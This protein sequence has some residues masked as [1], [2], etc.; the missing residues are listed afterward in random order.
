MADNNEIIKC[1][2]EIYDLR[3]YKRDWCLGRATVAK[4]KSKAFREG[5]DIKIKG[6]IPQIQIGNLYNVMLE[7]DDD[8]KYGLQYMVKSLFSAITFRAD[9]VVGQKRFL[10]SIFTTLQVE[11][12]YN[13][14]EDPYSVLEEGDAA[15]LVQVKGVGMKKAESYI[16]RFK[17]NLNKARIYVELEDFNLTNNMIDKLLDRYT[18]PE[19]V[20]QKVKDNPY[21]LCNEVGGIG[22]KTADRIAMDGGIGPHSPKR[23]TAFIAHY[24]NL[25]GENGSSWITPDELMGAILEELGE[26]IPDEPISESLKSLIDDGTVWHSENKDKIGLRRYYEIERKIAQELIRIRDAESNIRVP[27]NWRDILKYIEQNQGWSFTDEQLNGIETG[28]KN[29]I[30]V[31]TGPGG[32]VD[33]DTEYF[34]G[35]EWKKISEYTDEEKVLQYSGDGSAQLVYPINYIKKK[36]SHLWHF[37]TKYGLDQCLS[38]DHQVCYI[39]SK[40]NIYSKS[41]SE[42]MQN[43]QNTSTGFSGKFI[44]TFSYEGH[45]IDLTDDEIRLMVAT[46]ADGSFDYRSVCLSDDT[47]RKA[48]FHLKKKRKKDRLVQLFN[49]C[50]ISYTEKESAEKG[51][52]DYYAIVPFRAKHFPKEWYNCSKHQFEIIADEALYWDSYFNEKNNFVS[53]NKDDADFI[54][55]VN[56][57]LGKRTTIQIDDRVGQE[58][59]TANKK[60]IRQSIAYNV[61]TTN[62]TLICLDKDKRRPGGETKFEKYIPLDGY[63][64]CFSVPSN[65]LVLR[66]NNKI[67]ITGNCGKTSIVSGILEVLKGYSRVSCA[68]SGRA[69]SRMQEVTGEEGKTIHSLLGY[70]KGNKNGFVYHD[71]N[72]L[73]ADIYIVDEISMLDA[74]LFYNLLRAIPSGSKLFLLG[75]TAQLEAIGTG[76]IAHDIIESDEISVSKL[77]KIHRQAA[78]SAIITESIKLRNG[79]QLIEKNW[80]GQE[81]RGELQ[82]LYLSCFSDINNTFYKITEIFSTLMSYPEFDILQ[83]QIIVPVKSRGNACTYELNNAI[84]DLYNPLID[85]QREEIIFNSGKTYVFREGDKVINRVNNYKV[86]PSIYNGNIGIIQGWDYNE[87]G[88]EIMIIDFIGIGRVEL[89]KKFWNNLE[90]AYAITTHLSQGSEFDYVIYGLDFS[91]YAL[92]T[93]EQVYTAITRAKKKC[94]LI[95]QTGALR[96][97]ISKEAVSKKQTHLQQCLYDVAHPKLI[98]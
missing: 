33:C 36:C 85:N 84:Q 73:D 55:F 94:Y 50:N 88:E 35:T 98:F 13:T 37:S 41:F 72:Q 17:E 20:I 18:S 19:M 92:L 69:A 11:E 63:Q 66:R 1:T 39:T 44:T 8:P 70:P 43:H 45:G 2:I 64:Y 49:N 51:Y 90:L 95:A 58:Y 47:Y 56:T 80:V 31:I 40:G 46:F 79:Y 6:V 15:S 83:T 5:E 65:M 27:S 74:F 87:E 23:I 9:D 96:L 59:I 67:F 53:T 32:C 89:I 93:R 75:D 7:K 52:T 62:R 42:V 38:E 76:N 12:M 29:N 81:T 34:N 86:E 57:S 82:D 21:T 71:E 97:A 24:L 68:L 30:T 61:N 78:K 77:T 28:L 14:L 91:S 25:V 48:R 16:R 26:D 3:R 10:S 60:Y 4:C 54:Q 22:W